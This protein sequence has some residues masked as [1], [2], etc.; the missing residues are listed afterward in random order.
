MKPIVLYGALFVLLTSCSTIPPRND[1][2]VGLFELNDGRPGPRPSLVANDQADDAKAVDVSGN[3]QWPLK[4]VEIS[5]PYGMR[6]RKF[7]S[8]TDL[9]A[10]TGTDVFAAS[11][12]KVVY[13]ASR[14]RGYG[15]M[16][17]LQHADEVYS[18]YAHNSKN[19]VKVGQGVAR[20]DRIAISG[21]SGRV[22]GAHLHF[23]IRKG[24]HPIDPE[25]V[26]KVAGI[27]NRNQAN[28]IAEDKPAKSKRRQK[29]RG[30]ASSGK[31]ERSRS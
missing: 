15:R 28:M 31:K 25:Q 20:G 24:V 5:S 21:R 27:F 1:G 19:L 10:R 12:G 4:K 2:R 9:R 7:H 29:S 14:I 13:S 11:S 18:V 26:T 8:G 16:V 30:V 22:T 23:E 17:V 3:W 6:G